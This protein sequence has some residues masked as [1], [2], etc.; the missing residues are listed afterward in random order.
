M[1]RTGELFVAFWEI[2]YLIFFLCRKETIGS[3]RHKQTKHRRRRWL[4]FFA[5]LEFIFLTSIVYNACD[6]LKFVKICAWNG[7]TTPSLLSSSPW[8][9]RKVWWQTRFDIQ[10]N[11]NHSAKFQNLLQPC[12]V[13]R[14]QQLSSSLSCFHWATTCARVYTF[15]FLWYL[16][17]CILQLRKITMLIHQQDQNVRSR[18]EIH[19]ILF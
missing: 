7:T 16:L 6:A 4:H 8:K 15:I 9:S 10:C 14:G 5:F 11:T 13:Y 3:E 2:N 1:F 18:L 12:P 17:F 19:W